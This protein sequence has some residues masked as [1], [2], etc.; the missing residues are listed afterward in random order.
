MCLAATYWARIGAI[1]F[2]CNAEDAAKAGFD[3]AFLYRE[4][5]VPLAER[6]L[7]IENLLP[8]EA[9]GRVCGVD[10]EPDEGGILNDSGI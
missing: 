8:T 4:M 5:K 3:D 9:W 1:Y 2:G 7:P 6:T 10:R